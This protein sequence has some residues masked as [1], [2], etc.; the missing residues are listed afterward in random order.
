VNGAGRIPYV[1]SLDLDAGGRSPSMIPSAQ[2]RTL[3]S[4]S[5]A[6]LPPPRS[7]RPSPPMRAALSD[8]TSSRAQNTSPITRRSPPRS[9]LCLGSRRSASPRSK[10][11]RRA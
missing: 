7:S 3:P 4:I 1:D 5:A 6:T 9:T 11:G 8:A 10:P 2:S